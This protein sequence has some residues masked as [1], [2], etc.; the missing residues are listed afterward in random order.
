MVGHI[1]I[2][3]KANGIVDVDAQSN[4][5]QD[6]SGGLKKFRSGAVINGVSISFGSPTVWTLATNYGLLQS[7]D[8]GSSWSVI[9]TLVTPGSTAIQN[10]AVNPRD[11]QEMIITV[12][13]KLHHTR[14]AGK[15]WTVLTIP[16]SRTPVALTF[17]PVRI[18][19]LYIGTYLV[20]KK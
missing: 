6:L 3:T 14:D 7:F 12:G 4:N 2:F 8:R 1:Y 11:Q 9:P 17:D 19:R 15:T 10:V 20:P 18:D 5:W 16:T 13:S